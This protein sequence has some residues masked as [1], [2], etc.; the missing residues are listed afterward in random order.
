[1]KQPMTMQTKESQEFE[2]ALEEFTQATNHL[3]SL[4][5]SKVEEMDENMKKAQV[6]LELILEKYDIKK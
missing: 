2:K 3:G 6:N 1:M 5:C 4:I